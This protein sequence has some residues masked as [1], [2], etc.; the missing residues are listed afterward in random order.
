MKTI[1]F[2]CTGNTCRSSMAEG[3]F[4]YM[5]ENKKD[6]VEDIKV[7]SAGTSA[8][9][10][11][12]ASPQAVEVLKEKG[13]DLRSHR[14]TLLTPELIQEADLILTMTY[15]HKA[16]VL[17]MCPEAEDKVFT[18]KEYVS[19]QEGKLHRVDSNS[20]GIS[21]DIKD[22]FG[23]STEVYRQSAEEIEECLKI[24]LEKIL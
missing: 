4:K 15:N 21:Y 20:E 17:H 22:P 19:L 23:Q 18:L 11:Q 5:L 1:L 14:S 8:W 12:N 7:I 6:R 16:V 3:L 2:V 24:L 13:I 9:A 10:G